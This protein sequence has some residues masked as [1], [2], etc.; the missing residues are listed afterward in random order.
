[1]FERVRARRALLPEFKYRPQRTCFVGVLQKVPTDADVPPCCRKRSP[2]M[3]TFFES[4]ESYIE[5]VPAVPAAPYSNETLPQGIEPWVSNSM[6][7]LLL[8]E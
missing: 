4:A 1:M 8:P 6:A 2:A 5:G 3:V 7:D